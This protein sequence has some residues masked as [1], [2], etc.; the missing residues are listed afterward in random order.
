[1]KPAASAMALLAVV[2]ASIFANPAAALPHLSAHG[3]LARLYLD[4]R[5]GAHARVLHP[6]EA[7]PANDVAIQGTA[8]AQTSPASS[9]TTREDSLTFPPQP[10]LITLAPPLS[11]PTVVEDLHQPPEKGAIHDRQ[12]GHWPDYNPSLAMEKEESLVA[13]AEADADSEENDDQFGSTNTETGGGPGLN[14]R[15][16][17][18]RSSSRIRIL[19][20][21]GK[22]KPKALSSGDISPEQRGS[23]QMHHE[24][25]AE[26]DWRAWRSQFAVQQQW[27]RC[28]ELRFGPCPDDSGDV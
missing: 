8:A 21:K 3:L 15:G 27:R 11:T 5:L 24:E 16:H 12:G 13:E 17:Y 14:Y 18:R 19:A 7:P 4:A 22:V 2:L 10:Q 20:S 1:M 9:S 25:A 6:L 28:R 26:D 23:R